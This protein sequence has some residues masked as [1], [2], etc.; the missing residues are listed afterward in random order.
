MGVILYM[1]GK[2]SVQRTRRGLESMKERVELSGRSFTIGSSKTKGTTI[3]RVAP[4]R[5]PR[6]GGG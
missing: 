3:N 6:R 2:A 5:V 4:F 1:A